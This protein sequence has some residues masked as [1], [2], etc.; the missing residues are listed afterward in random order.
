[1][2]LLKKDSASKDKDLILSSGTLIKI[3]LN[4]GYKDKMSVDSQ[5]NIGYLLWRKQHYYNE[6]DEDE[7]EKY[8]NHL[9]FILDG[10]VK[11]VPD[12]MELNVKMS[13]GERLKIF[14]KPIL[15]GEDTFA[16]AENVEKTEWMKKAI[17][18]LNTNVFYILEAEYDGI[19]C[20]TFFEIQKEDGGWLRSLTIDDGV[21]CVD[22]IKVNH[23][24][25]GHSKNLEDLLLDD[26]NVVLNFIGSERPQLNISRDSIVKEDINRF[27]EKLKVLLDKLIKQAIDKTIMYISDNHIEPNS[28]QYISVW[29]G[30]FY[31]FRFVPVS[32][33]A[34]HF[35]MG[36]IKDYILPLP[37]NLISNE[38]TFGEFFSENVCFE[39]YYRVHS[40]DPFWHQLNPNPFLSL[41]DNRIISS[42]EISGNEKKMSLKGF[43]KD[44][45]VKE[46][47]V[48]S[49]DWRIFDDYDLIPY[50]API[51]S[52]RFDTWFKQSGYKGFVENY[53]IFDYSLYYA[54]NEF[55]TLR[56]GA[57]F[58]FLSKKKDVFSEDDFV[59]KFSVLLSEF[60][61]TNRVLFLKELTEV[62]F[63]EKAIIVMYSAIPEELY[64]KALS[65]I[66]PS[67]SQT[68]EDAIE[69]GLSIIFFGTSDRNGDFYVIA[70]RWSRQELVDKIPDDIWDNLKLDEYHFIDDTPL[71]RSGVRKK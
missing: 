31:R 17:T 49:T 11:V 67:F 9:Y 36:L 45:T 6:M 40:G 61:N 18:S 35:T 14:N 34:Q 51:V 5:D 42:K 10:F 48:V 50:L 53:F 64:S 27:D 20:S 28:N 60:I 33:Y 25:Y 58:E 2:F 63:D 46:E 41:I 19:Q 57:W 39:G 37:K 55:S 66:S 62:Y 52:Q 21:E 3:Y 69:G 30:F 68:I 32:I 38:M 12:N 13:G 26:L 23:Y 8:A 29:D 71:Q 59:Q 65:Q 24:F 15:M 54:I 47:K 56:G 22:G 16:F 4:D 7:K 1:M 70:G 43:R 44:L